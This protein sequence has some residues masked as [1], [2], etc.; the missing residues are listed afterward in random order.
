MPALFT[1]APPLPFVNE[2]LSLV[3]FAVE[4]LDDCCEDITKLFILAAVFVCAS[5]ATSGLGAWANVDAA[6][7]W[8]FNQAV[9]VTAACAVYPTAD[10]LSD[11]LAQHAQGLQETLCDALGV[12]ASE[13]DPTD[14]VIHR[15]TAENMIDDVIEDVFKSVCVFSH[16]TMGALL[17][18]TMR[19]IIAGWVTG[20]DGSM[21]A[22][23]SVA[24][25][26]AASTLV[27]VGTPAGR[28]SKCDQFGDRLGDLVQD[29]LVKWLSTE[30]T[31]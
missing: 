16:Y 9:A 31:K 17:G 15:T 12:P 14:L 10:H 25:G 2:F 13:P 24:A 6:L 11:T 7:M 30:G 20:M 26:N 8:W 1:W 3:T 23:Y 19:R 5:R 4:N 28:Y 29:T 18:G 27:I 22:R 21:G